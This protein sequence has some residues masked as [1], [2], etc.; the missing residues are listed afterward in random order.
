MVRSRKQNKRMLISSLKHSR[1]SRINVPTEQAEPYMDEKERIPIRYKPSL[2]RREDPALAWDRGAELEDLEAEAYPLYIQEKVHP[3]AWIKHL[4][5]NPFDEIQ[6]LF[7]DFNGLPVD[8]LYRWYE[9]EG[10]WQNRVIKGDSISVLASLAA[11]EG[12]GGGAQS[13]NAGLS[14]NIQMFFYDPPYGIGFKSNFQTRTNAREGSTNLKGLPVEPRA[15]KPF[16][17]TYVNGIHSYLDAVFKNATFARMI[18]AESGSFFMQIG[19]ENVNRCALILDE[20]FGAENRV[21]MIA[22][23]KTSSSSSSFMSN[24][25]DYLLWYAK[26]RS[27]LKYRQIFESYESLED[28]VRGFSWHAFKENIETGEVTKIKPQEFVGLSEVPEGYRIGRF[29]PLISQD[30]STTGRSDPF[31]WNGVT[32]KPPPNSHWRVSEEGLRSLGSQNR[33]HGE[34]S[35]VSL[36]WKW[37]MDEV[38]GKKINNVWSP[39]MYANDLH[40]VVETSEKVIERCLLMTT[41]PG[42]LVMDITC[43]S[44]TTAYVAEKWGRRWITCDSA[45]VPIQLVRQR[46][47]TGTFDWYVL[48]NSPEG[49]MDK[50]EHG[51]SQINTNERPDSMSSDPSQGFVYQRVPKVSA[52]ILAYKQKVPPI[53]LVNQPIKQKGI[54]RVAGPFTVESIS[55][56]RFASTTETQNEIQHERSIHSIKAVIDALE[57][58]G[59]DFGSIKITVDQIKPSSPNLCITHTGRVTDHE[60]KQFLAAICV[61]P[62]DETAS[63]ILVRKAAK[64]VAQVEDIAMLIVIAFAFEADTRGDSI[65]SMGRLQV[66]KAQANRDLMIGGLRDSANDRAIVAVGEPDVDLNEVSTGLWVV[67][68]K[69]WDSFDPTTGNVRRSDSEDGSIDTWMIDTNHNEVSFFANRIH[70]PS[71]DQDKQ[72]KRLKKAISRGLNQ[73]EWSAVTSF[74][75]SPFKTP[76]TGKIALRVITTTGMEMTSVIEVP[77]EN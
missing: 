59:I 11:K 31:N 23:Q 24:V 77:P 5:S 49:Q 46:I 12:Y 45:S 37:Y 27:Q 56:Y 40:Y 43:G 55:P 54:L 28:V 9:F 67:S 26:D 38:P 6:G 17:D 8:S 3:E 34:S 57:I 2:R 30:E 76:A 32:W 60:G 16:R 71:K 73:S 18:M 58:S 41:D 42:D 21:S 35:E 62:D 74:E 75:S 19:Q 50:L 63:Q 64:E 70:F 69:G 61:L 25:C 39:H 4:Q 44:G 15:I 65:Y 29:L 22:F 36:T 51:D 68:L 66:V 33:L 72:I 20:V 53:E 13:G 7:S 14:K 48:R 52:G 47:L 1:S 10:N